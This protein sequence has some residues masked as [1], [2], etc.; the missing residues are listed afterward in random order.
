MDGQIT[1]VDGLITGVY[2]NICF[3]IVRRTTQVEPNVKRITPLNHVC[4]RVEFENVDSD[5]KD[6]DEANE[7]SHDPQVEV[8]NDHAEE[9]EEAEAP[10]LGRG[11]RMQTPTDLYQ[12]D[13][14]NI[15]YKYPD[16]ADVIHSCCHGAGYG[17]NKELT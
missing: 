12:A 3:R 17:G 15:R 4:R 2:D 5:D 11:H 8:S 1:E 16:K 14:S 9:E 10:Q 7:S 6:D 13:F